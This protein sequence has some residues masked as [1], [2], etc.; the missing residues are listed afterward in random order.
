M[1]Q[2]RVAAA[3]CE[4]QH[5]VMHCF[6]CGGHTYRDV[7]S[8]PYGPNTPPKFAVDGGARDR[9]GL[10]TASV[11]SEHISIHWHPVDKEIGFLIAGKMPSRIAAALRPQ[12]QLKPARKI[13]KG[14]FLNAIPNFIAESTGRFQLTVPV[15]EHIFFRC[16]WMRWGGPVAARYAGAGSPHHGADMDAAP[17]RRSTFDLQVPGTG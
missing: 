8:D 2:Q 16:L 5:M 11:Q 15:F 14:L 3:N 9:R 13:I 6:V 10:G 17:P 1:A 7:V 12:L 4:R